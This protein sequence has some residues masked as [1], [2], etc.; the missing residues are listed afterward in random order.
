MPIAAPPSA[1][2]SHTSG[3]AYLAPDRPLTVIM[4]AFNEERTVARSIR[5][6]LAACPE[7]EVLVVDDGST[8]RTAGIVR[9]LALA[10]R[11]PSW[12]SVLRHDENR[13]KGAAIRTALAEARG[14][15]CAIQD[16]DLEYDPRDLTPLL[17]T[18]RSSQP[19]LA[20]YGSRYL[21][22]DSTRPPGR[23]VTE[24]GIATLNGLVW[25]LYGV[26]TTDHATCYKLIPRDLLRFLDIR[27]TGFE[28]C[29]EVTAK[30]GRAYEFLRE[31]GQPPAAPF[32]ERA[33]GY[34]P[35]SRAEGKKLQW[36]V[37]WGVARTLLRHRHWT[38]DADALIE[39]WATC[40]EQL[41][42]AVVEPVL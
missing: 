3:E 20:T 36:N 33:I 14:V 42:D 38:P 7:A 18:L 4:P 26:R 31:N 8:D 15:V 21:T 1:R 12:L 28:W 11:R 35:R 37:G 23:P 25:W 10:S 34:R 40:R 16:A 22:A 27:A 30:L 32:I 2:P 39:V 13:G 24:A 6:V 19:P 41:C 17:Q 9:E 5:A 29:A